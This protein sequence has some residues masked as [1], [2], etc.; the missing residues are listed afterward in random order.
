MTQSRADK[1]CGIVT[2]V[3]ILGTIS[4]TEPQKGRL[5]HLMDAKSRNEVT[6]C[7]YVDDPDRTHILRSVIVD[8]LSI[9]ISDS[10]SGTK[11]SSCLNIP[12]GTSL[13]RTDR[14]DFLLTKAL[15]YLAAN[16]S[17]INRM[18]EED[19]EQ[20][21][22]GFIVESELEELAGFLGVDF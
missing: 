6:V 20:H 8:D 18:I 7:V 15:C 14:Q 17:D 5:S 22:Q 3:S 21:T 1:N 11:L 12:H 16:L 19:G 10:L 2:E 4:T 9:R 13:T